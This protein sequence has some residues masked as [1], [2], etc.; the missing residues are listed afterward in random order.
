MP[1]FNVKYQPITPHVRELPTSTAMLLQPMT[2]EGLG[3]ELESDAFE[4]VKVDD[5]QSAFKVFE[6]KI[7]FKSE[8]PT[9]MVVDLAFQRMADFDPK[10]ILKPSPT[11]ARNDLAKLQSTIS[12]L[13]RLKERWAKPTVRKAWADKAQRQQIIEAIGSLRSELQTM[14]GDKEK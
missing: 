11:G 2:L 12:L 10:N 5:L 1:E 14:V 4:P 3:K 13:Y 6:P 8:G 9:E 7:H